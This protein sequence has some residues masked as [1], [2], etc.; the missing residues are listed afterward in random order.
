VFIKQDYLMGMMQIKLLK[1]LY[2]YGVL[3]LLHLLASGFLGLI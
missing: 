1:I 3:G 2:L